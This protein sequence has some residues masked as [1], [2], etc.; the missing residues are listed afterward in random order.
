MIPHSAPSPVPLRVPLLLAAALLL[1]TGPAGAQAGNPVEAALRVGREALR[2]GAPAEAVT[3]LE[4]ATRA[5]PQ[6]PPVWL[7]LG[8]ALLYD[9]RPEEARDAYRQASSLLPDEPGLRWYYL[10]EFEARR[11]DAE[12]ETRAPAAHTP[13]APTGL[14]GPWLGQSDPGVTPQVFAPGVVSTLGRTEIHLSFSPDGR[15]LYLTTRED[16]LLVSRWREGGWTAPAL[17]AEGPLQGFSEINVSP[18]G[19]RLWGNR[20]RAA[21]SLTRTAEGWGNPVLRFP[22]G[23]FASEAA[24][25]SVYFTLV[26][27]EGGHVVRS[28]PEAN[29]FGE[30]ERAGG[31]VFAPEGTA[32][33]FIA[34]DGRLLLFDSPRRGGVGGFD[35]WMSRRSPDGSWGDAVPLGLE[36]NSRGQN[37]CAYLTPDGRY[38]FFTR[39]GDIWWVS[40]EILGPNR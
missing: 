33:P 22:D 38:L 24:D 25:G 3:A 26:R 9:G 8:T 28:L 12:G 40:A 11:E 15:E 16:G 6:V 14:A 29:G 20:E 32:H 21:W 2:R 4:A 7:E 30:P 13:G 37:M 36:V 10:D 27:P 39:F 35:L 17:V 19:A 23:M 31:G 1:L 18:D 5:Y 34:P